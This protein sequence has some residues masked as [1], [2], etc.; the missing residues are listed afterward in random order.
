MQQTHYVDLD[1][2][3]LKK[4]CTEAQYEHKESDSDKVERM[5]DRKTKQR[6]HKQQGTFFLNPVFSGL[7]TE[8]Q[9]I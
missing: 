5:T 6:R 8:N 2:W 3:T 9:T 7:L 4:R 1:E